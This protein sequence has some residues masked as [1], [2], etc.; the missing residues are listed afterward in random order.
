MKLVEYEFGK[1]ENSVE[2]LTAKNEILTKKIDS[3]KD[4]IETLRKA[5]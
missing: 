4:T 3:Q 1:N 2:V 5:L